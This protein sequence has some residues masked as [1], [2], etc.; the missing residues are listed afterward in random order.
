MKDTE[1]TLSQKHSTRLA[2]PYLEND[3][4]PSWDFDV[5]KWAG[6]Y[7]STS[8]DLAKYLNQFVTNTPVFDKKVIAMT[9]EV[10]FVADPNMKMSIGWHITPLGDKIVYWHNGNT[11]GNAAFVG[12]TSDGDFLAML[13]NSNRILDNFA[14]DILSKMK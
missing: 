14:V 11:Y 1:L 8:Q 10:T 9:K 4:V 6:A 2:Q 13:S 5:F 7:Y 12:F 3:D